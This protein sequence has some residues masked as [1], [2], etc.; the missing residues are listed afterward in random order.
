[1]ESKEVFHG[2][3]QDKVTY[4]HKTLI[5]ESKIILTP[6]DVHRIQRIIW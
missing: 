3:E 2:A 6:E 5:V 4:L 1:M